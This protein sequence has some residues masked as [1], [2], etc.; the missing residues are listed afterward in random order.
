VRY[1][2]SLLDTLNRDRVR[3]SARSGLTYPTFFLY[4]YRLSLCNFVISHKYIFV[5][6]ILTLHVSLYRRKWQE[7]FL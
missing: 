6:F 3:K 5:L 1:Y 7:I 2:C 4:K